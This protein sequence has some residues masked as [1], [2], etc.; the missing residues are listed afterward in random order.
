MTFLEAEPKSEIILI[1]QCF[2]TIEDITVQNTDDNAW[3]GRIAV[4]VNGVE[5]PLYCVECGG[6]PFDKYIVVDGDSNYRYQE[7]PTYCKNGD[8]CT[9]SVNEIKGNFLWFQLCKIIH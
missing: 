9:L 6:S 4:T 5:T 2:E 7:A 3:T 1:D 8:A